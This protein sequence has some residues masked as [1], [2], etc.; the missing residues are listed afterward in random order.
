[1]RETSVAQDGSIKSTLTREAGQGIFKN[2]SEYRPDYTKIKAPALSFYAISG[3]P[4]WIPSDEE[5]R[6][7]AREF[8]DN[9]NAPYQRKNIE[10]FKSE[11][12]RGRVIEVRDSHHYLFIKNLD[13]V[14]REMRT[15]LLSR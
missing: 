4:L 2:A 8:L 9:A 13:E 10:K 3:L 6:R 15:F 11:M 1:L 7:K 5:A 14:V 12:R